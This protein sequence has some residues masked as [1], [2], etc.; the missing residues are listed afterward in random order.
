MIKRIC[1][2][3]L[4]SIMLFGCRELESDALINSTDQ[5]GILELKSINNRFH[6]QIFS[7][8]QLTPTVLLAGGDTGRMFKISTSTENFESYS[9]LGEA[10]NIIALQAADSLKIVLLNSNS[11]IGFSTDGGFN[12][13]N[14]TGNLDS[15]IILALYHQT[16]TKYFY[17][18]TSNGLIYRRS[19]ADTCWNQITNLYRPVTS[20]TSF[21][22]MTLYAGTWSSGVFKINLQTYLGERISSGLLNPYI[23]SLH[24]GMNNKLF[25]GSYGGGVFCSSNMGISWYNYS[26]VFDT[27]NITGINTTS[28]NDLIASTTSKLYFIKNNSTMASVGIVDST[29]ILINALFIGNN[30]LIYVGTN[31]G[32]FHA[33]QR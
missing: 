24:A 7:I 11:E 26:K 22:S 5:I 25:A 15:I 23:Q 4:L 27:C 20:F 1:W 29:N 28:N 17:I 33:I 14:W 6:H 2:I 32:I 3:L 18:G 8:A 31:E 16:S 10:G 12:W 9:P 30:D 19:F 13:Q 21:D